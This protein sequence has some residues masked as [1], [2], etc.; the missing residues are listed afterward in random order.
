MK[1]RLAEQTK[2][3]KSAEALKRIEERAAQLHQLHVEAIQ[4]RAARENRRAEEV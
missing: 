3:P 2:S 1:A 4:Q